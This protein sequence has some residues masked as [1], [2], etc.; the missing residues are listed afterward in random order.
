[1][2]ATGNIRVHTLVERLRA[3]AADLSGY[4]PNDLDTNSSFL[5]LGFDSL[6]LTQLAAAFQREYGLKITF[7]QLFDELP[8]LRALAEYIDGK[9]PPDVLPAREAVAPVTA[10]V[11]RVESPSGQQDDFVPNKFTEEYVGSSRAGVVADMADGAMQRV[12]AQQLELM[13]KQLSVL[14]NIKTAGWPVADSGIVPDTNPAV[15]AVATS[16]T[17]P[18]AAGTATTPASAEIGSPPIPA[19]FGPSIKRESLVL[20]ERQRQHIDRLTARYNARTMASKRHTQMHR[21]HHADPRT[22]AGFNRLWKDMVYPIVIERSSGCRLQD[23]DGN[24]Y[25]D[26][27]N[28]F[29]PNFLGHSPPF[30]SEALKAQIEKGIEV[31]PQTPLAGEAAKLMCEI[32]G[33]DRV[34]WVNTGSEAVQAAIRLSRTYTGRSKIVVFSGD[35]HGNFDEVLVRATGK[36]TSRRTLPLAPGIP[37]GAVEQVLVLDYGTDESLTIIQEHAGE[38]AAVLVE[39]VQSRRPEFQPREFLQ[40]LRKLTE[41]EG[42]VLVFDEV[43][44]GFRICPGGAQQYFDV[45]ADLATYGKIIGGGMPI[46]VVAGR[47]RFMDTFD[48]GQWQYNDDSFPAAGVT[49]FAGTFVRHPLAIAAVHATLQYLKAQG[50]SLQDGVNRRTTR[51]VSELNAFFEERE[52][53]FKVDHF[54]SQ[55]FIRV[56]EAG[57][58]GT[59]LFYHL[60]DRGIHVLEN[61][62]SYLTAAHTDQDIDE[63]IAAFKDSV[64][65]MQEDDILPKPVAAQT[66]I[67]HWRHRMPLTAGQSEVWLASQMSDM[68]SCAFNESD[69]VLIRGALDVGLF[70]K[71]VLQVLT[72]QEAFHYRFDG[73][74]ATQW[75]DPKARFELP[76]VDWSALNS[77]DREHRLSDLIDHQAMMPFDLENGPLVRVHLVKLEQDQFLFL[78]YCHHLVFDG[79]SSQIV[80]SKIT[81]LYTALRKGVADSVVESTPYSV[82]VYRSQDTV[83]EPALTE[84]LN[85]WHDVLGT[86]VPAPL[87]LP[88]DRPRDASRSYRGATAHR[89]IDPTLCAALRSLAK[90]LNAS[91][92]GL[93]MTSFQALLSRLSGQEDLVLGIPVAGQAR[94]SLDVVGYCVDLLPI[95]AK[96]ANDKPFSTLVRETQLHLL[97][98]LDNQAASLSAIVR[99]LNIPRDPSRLPLIE[100]VFNYS[101]YFSD[102]EI[103]DCVVSTRENPRRAIYFDMFFNVIECV[104]RLVIDWDY[105][106]DLYDPETID[107]WINHYIELLRGV[108]GNCEQPVGNLPLVADDATVPTSAMWG[109]Q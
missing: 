75:V 28:G 42:I 1:M 25:I 64:L 12:M 107:C 74:G 24:R 100:V 91:F 108:V 56:N 104:D 93:L 102:L 10:N 80:M 49:F 90:S 78:I 81:D 70:E 50:P 29:G 68:A 48:G 62:P 105:N 31:G 13:A 71:A 86:D 87:D 72:E 66:G 44:T 83:T 53:K 43:I 14:R 97:D 59:L 38:I 27:L 39:P 5:D 95:R 54:A 82:Y 26:I 65:E 61:F 17:S 101:S 35:Y 41:R 52:V 60:R 79:Y 77:A 2:T 85:Y 98:A 106:R 45:K 11:N 73:D 99:H 46:G 89:E 69:S 15:R 37:F 94:H 57:E 55:M 40:A 8:T 88:S 21:P 9:L 4:E 30:V 76:F 51:L 96:P 33:M 34:S 84:S 92:H 109:R 16:A 63:I 23:L 18:I 6:F 3:L 32:T 103:P 58:L 19:G 22:A 67:V 47:S 36:T 20:S 7:R